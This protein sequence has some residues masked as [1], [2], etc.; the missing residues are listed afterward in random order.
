M[1]V[2]ALPD[3]TGCRPAAT[4]ARATLSTRARLEA[5][6]VTATL[7][8]QPR[9]ND[10]RLTRTLASEPASP[11]TKTLVLSHTMASAPS[12]PMR[13]NVASSVTSPSSGSGSKLLDNASFASCRSSILGFS[14]ISTMAL[15]TASAPSTTSVGAKSLIRLMSPIM[16]CSSPLSAISS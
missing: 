15:S 9:T 11:G 2:N 3:S 16:R 7:P 12:S 10:S 1:R 13:F 4:A 6:Q 8:V 14:E 5:K